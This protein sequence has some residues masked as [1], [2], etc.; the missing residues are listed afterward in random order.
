MGTSNTIRIPPPLERRKFLI[1]FFQPLLPTT[2]KYISWHPAHLSRGRIGSLQALHTVCS[3]LVTVSE[4]SLC[5]PPSRFHL[6]YHF[7]CTLFVQSIL[8]SPHHLICISND[9]SKKM[10]ACSLFEVTTWPHRPPSKIFAS[11]RSPVCLWERTPQTVQNK[12]C[13]KPNRSGLSIV[14]R[15]IHTYALGYAIPLLPVPA[16]PFVFAAA[17]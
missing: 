16:Y 8:C 15:H 2:L 3:G 13:P 11:D 4:H 1:L 6:F 14:S 12:Q 5:L 17:H 7:L 10:A 9:I